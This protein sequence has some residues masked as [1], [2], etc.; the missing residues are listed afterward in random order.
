VLA[1]DAEFVGVFEIF[2][3]RQKKLRGEVPDVY[4][5]DTI[6]EP[7]RVQIIHIW[8]DTLG[9]PED[10]AYSRPLTLRAY[11]LIVEALCR[12]YGVFLLGGKEIHGERNY[13]LDLGHFLLAERGPEKALD[14]IELSF[15]V[16]DGITR[17]WSHQAAERAD[18]AIAELNARFQ[19]HG[20]GYAFEDGEIIRVDSQLLHAEAVKP[21]LILL[22]A[23]DYAGAQ[24]EFLTAHEHYRHGREKE[25]LAECLKAIESVMKA[26]CAKRKWVHDPNAPAKALIEVLFDKGLVPAFWS[27]HFHAL[28]S[29]LEAGVPTARN[30][31]GGH[32]QG[33][34]VVQV[35]KYIVAYV[36]HMTASAIVFL[37]EAEKALP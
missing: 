18:G 2:S 31:L 33:T 35:P 6:P 15:R 30:K 17:T 27:S 12:E 28:R 13:L 29:T 24:A 25:A 22:A 20:V 3:K 32:G 34:E 23:P 8:N 4:T 11:R 21:A 19:E 26:I 10:Y 9:S 5:Y 16:I 36:L 7:L 1:V 14:A 37:A